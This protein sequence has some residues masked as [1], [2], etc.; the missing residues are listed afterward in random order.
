MSASDF[1]FSIG[2]EEK[3]APRRAFRAK[4][5]GLTIHVPDKGKSYAVADLSAMGLAFMDESRGFKEGQVVEFDLLISKKVFLSKLTVKVMRL[6]D[7]GLVGCNFE[8]VDYRKEAK[9]DK[10]VLEVQKRM[11][12]LKKKSRE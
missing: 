5:P 9:L 1:D 2:G 10:L 7:N 8:G 6:L 11:I 3:G 4:I 12:A